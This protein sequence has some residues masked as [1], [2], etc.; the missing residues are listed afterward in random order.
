MKSRDR[1]LTSIRF[2]MV[3]ICAAV[4]LI[5]MSVSGSFM[6]INVRN[7]EIEN[8]RGQLMR[9]ALSVNDQI[10]QIF[11]PGEWLDEFTFRQPAGGHDIQ[12]VVLSATGVVIAPWEFREPQFN[13]ND[14]AVISAIAG[15]PGF[16]VGTRALDLNGMEHEWIAYAIP[17]EVYEDGEVNLYI[18]YTRMSAR[19][20]NDSLSQLTAYIVMMV[21]M[22]L[23]ITVVLWF[24]FAQTISGPIVSLTRQAK[25]MAQGNL[26]MK[27]TVYSQ[28]EIGQL[29]ESFNHMAKELSHMVSSLALEKNKHETVLHNMTDGVIAYDAQGQITHANSAA[30]AL[31]MF[32]DL[33][34]QTL[35]E[36]LPHLG[37][38]P[39]EV[40]ALTPDRVLESTIASGDAAPS[41]GSGSSSGTGPSGGTGARY[42]TASCSPYANQQGIVDGYVIVLQDITRHAKLDNMRRE[43]VANV[44]HELRTP[45]ASICSYAETLLNDTLSDDPNTTEDFLR[46]IDT[47]AK[48]MSLLVKDLLELSRL[49]DDNPID[50]EREVIDLVGLTKMAVKHCIVSAEEKGQQIIFREL[51]ESAEADK[52]PYFIE[53][54]PNR[55]SQVLINILSNSIKYS[56]PDTDIEVALEETGRFYR[57]L[58]RDYGMGIPKEHLSRIFE[59]FYRVDK[60][61]S[62]A[63]G[64]TGLGLAIAKE[65]MKVH[66]GRITA[67]SEPGVGTTMVLRFNKLAD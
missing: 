42:I 9:R 67:T 47:E 2:K 49:D 22:A 20:I 31:L 61:R 27:V 53:A 43:F 55:I 3:S 34:Q 7:T 35:L 5:V 44:S 33:E 12:E 52:K 41:S 50:M 16:T 60:A 39:E 26:N 40:Y 18:I 10:I 14:Q 38:D 1:V 66:G 17:V 19:P 36:I 11:P 48:R 62:R 64:G 29:T 30:S 56:P 51:A 54:S 6:L 57:V 8:A 65:I 15:E 25:E 32:D 4:V 13:F 45:L 37:F 58:I 21:L 28:D 63:L 23:F 46:V 24:L 59:R